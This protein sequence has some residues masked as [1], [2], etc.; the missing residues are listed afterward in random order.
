MMFQLKGYEITVENKS[1]FTVEQLDFIKQGHIVICGEIGSGKSTF[2]KSLI[3]FQEFS[4]ELKF[5]GQE[6]VHNQANHEIAYVP[7]NL[8]YYFI[9]ANVLDEILFSTGIV[10]ATAIKLLEKYNLAH[11]K[12][13]SPQVLSGGEK[14]RLVALINEANRATCLILDETVSMNDYEN[15][16]LISYEIE[17]IIAAGTLVVEISH[18]INRIRLANQILFIHNQQIYEFG[19]FANFIKDKDVAE[20]WGIND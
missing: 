11:T 13:Q 6:V 1:L 10:E 16:Q 20:V 2:A 17:Q 7:Q 14:V 9:M 18:D 3:G 15:T 12:K 19:S 5:D 4:G 8:E